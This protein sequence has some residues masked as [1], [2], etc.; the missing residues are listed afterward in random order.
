MPA[1]LPVR[2]PRRLRLGAHSSSLTLTGSVE[3]KGLRW[4]RAPSQV[5]VS[6]APSQSPAPMSVRNVCSKSS[7]SSRSVPVHG[8]HRIEVAVAVGAGDVRRNVLRV[9]LA[10]V[11][12][13][14]GGVEG[15]RLTLVGPAIAGAGGEAGAAAEVHRV[16]QRH[17]ELGEVPRPAVLA[18]EVRVAALAGDV[19]GIVRGAHERAGDV[20][21]H[22]AGGLTRAPQAV[23]VAG[24]G[25]G[26]VVRADLELGDASRARALRV[27]GAELGRVVLARPALRTPR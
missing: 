14:A 10:E 16:A 23:T 15:T 8:L 5:G 22:A 12:V 13:A 17:A 3:V 25:D 24:T 27:A 26:G 19:G 21:A 20:L 18:P 11:A 4:T 6:S 9:G 2:G 1:I 7:T